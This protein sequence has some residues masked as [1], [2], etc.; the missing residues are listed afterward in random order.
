[1]FRASD[2][3]CARSSGKLFAVRRL[4]LLGLLVPAIFL[5]AA[6]GYPDPYASNQGPRS[7]VA[8]TTA[9]PTPGTSK[10]DPFSLGAKLKLVK[11]PDGLEY[12]N[13]KVG[14]GKLAT[15]NSSATM[16]YTLYA[17]SGKF[18]QTSLGSSSGPFTTE[19]STSNVIAGFVEGVEGMRA[20][21]IRRI[22][23]PQSLGY[24]SSPPS[25]I[26]KGTL[27]FIVRLHDVT[28]PSPSPSPT[29]S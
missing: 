20:G 23:V 4:R 11:L 14:K 10:G 21:G 26:P 6:C 7:G 3:G 22:V 19:L 15:A 2:R 13:I 8:A 5:L 29:P 18:L 28:A 9:T 17:A 24:G 16:D 1:M 25:G 27:I 12:A